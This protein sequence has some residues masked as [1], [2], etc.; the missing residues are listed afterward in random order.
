MNECCDN[1]Y[2][3]CCCCRFVPNVV[4][5][6]TIVDAAFANV[7]AIV[8]VVV[9]IAFDNDVV[10]VADVQNT[11]LLHFSQHAPPIKLSGHDWLL[12]HRLMHLFFRRR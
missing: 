11:G 6:A 8:V 3:C 7:V 1:C 5:A 12:G 4:V 9:A 10:V 2:C